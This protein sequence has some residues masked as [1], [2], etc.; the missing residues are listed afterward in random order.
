MRVYLMTLL[1]RGYIAGAPERLSI[2]SAERC[3]HHSRYCNRRISLGLL[4]ALLVAAGPG[5]ALQKGEPAPNFSLTSTEG[6]VI[7]LADLSGKVVAI[8]FWATWGKHCPEELKQLQALSKEFGEKGL[9][10][11]GINERE[12]QDQ[13]AE[14]AEQNGITFRILLDEGGTARAFG[15]NGVPDLWVIDRKGIARARFIGYG[16]TVP[17]EIRDTVMAAL[18]GTLTAPEAATPPAGESGFIPAPLHAYAHLQLGAAHV[19]I[20]DA[21]IKAGYRDG[22]HFTEAVRELRAGVALDPKNVELHIWLGLALERRQ[23]RPAAVREYQTAVTLDPTNV[24][25]QD[26]LRRLGVPP[27]PPEEENQQ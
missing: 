7:L 23:E 27:T 21:F 12:G 25:A 20:G 9:V 10:A 24:Y 13:V 1:Y 17:K 15:V 6:E 5:W 22:G 26:A 16:P 19:N 8:S 18:A 14:F 4:A 2:C 3:L 11:L